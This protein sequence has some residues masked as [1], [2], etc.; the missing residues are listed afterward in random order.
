M[1]SAALSGCPSRLEM[2]GILGGLSTDAAQVG[3]ETAQDRLQHARV[4]SNVD[5][6]TLRLH[7]ARCAAGLPARPARPAGPETTHSS[8]AFT[9]AMS[10]SGPSWPR[11]SSAA[12]GT[13]SIP[14]GGT[15]SKS[16]PRRSTRPMQVLERHH[17]RQTR[18]RVL[19]H[20]VPDQC[21]WFE[22][23]QDIQS[24]ASAYSTIMISGSCNR[25]LL[26]LLDRCRVVSRRRAARGRARRSP[27]A[28]A[29]I[30]SPRSIQ[31]WNT[32]SVAY[33]SRAMPAY[34]APPPGNMNTHP[35]DRLPDGCG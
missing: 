25:G 17:T 33:S 11:T 21:R 13:L 16:R 27:A 12:S 30:S 22:H 32:G 24:C 23:P 8:G 3:L 1:A 18:R 7:L 15:V 20:A 28:A 35:P 31:S 26:E 19:A 29:W 14:P 9:L 2:M 4:R 5:L 34:C 10:S 6:Y